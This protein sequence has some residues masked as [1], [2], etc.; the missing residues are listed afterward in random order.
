MT[1]SAD[2]CCSLDFNDTNAMVY[3]EVAPTQTRS[4]PNKMS[5]P[6]GS[7]TPEKFSAINQANAS[8]VHIKPLGS[9]QRLHQEQAGS[10]VS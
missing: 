3:M 9:S 6:S 7:F 1:F 10:V 5:R 2:Q 4:S 8:R